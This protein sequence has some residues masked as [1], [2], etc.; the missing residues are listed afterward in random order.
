MKNFSDNMP[1]GKRFT[2]KKEERLS[3]R[4]QIEKL[5]SAGNSFL[6]YPLKV[7]YIKNEIPGI[8]PTRAGFAVSSKKFKKATERNLVKRRMR[9][10]YR[11][12]KYLLSASESQSPFSVMFIYVG[13]QILDYQFFEKAMKRSLSLIVKNTTQ[14]P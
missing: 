3:S 12:N 14:C 9:E 1:A 11:L 4:K 2:F 6:A 5:F 8:F 7:V 13:K 10:A